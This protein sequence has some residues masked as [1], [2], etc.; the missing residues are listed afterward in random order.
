MPD[1]AQAGSGSIADPTLREAAR[2]RLPALM[3]LLRRMVEL[4]TPSGDAGRIGALAEMMAD[5]MRQRGAD[6]RTV[7]AGDAGVHLVGRF[8][9]EDTSLEPLLVLGHLDTVHAAG[10]LAEM[11]F[12]QEGERVRGPGVYDM[13]GGV[14]AVLLGADLLAEW[15]RPRGPWTLVLTADEEVGSAT[16]RALIE[17]MA[18]ESRGA[19]VPEPCIPGGRVKT[20][21]KG[22][23]VYTLTVQGRAAHAGIEPERGAS[24]VHE[25]A[26]RVVELGQM[27]DAE[28]GTTV[29]VG[30]VRG[31]TRSNVVAARAEAEVDVRFWT[32]EEAERVDRMV[33]ELRAEDPDCA[34]TVQGGINRPALERTAGSGRLFEMARQEASALGFTLDEGGTGGASDGNFSAAVGC[35]TLDGLGPDGGGAHTPDEHVL[36]EDLPRRAA[37]MAALL[38]RL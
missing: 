23:A 36:V 21:R 29:N 35:P 16:S 34:L 5:E 13:K 10:T 20:R 14:A 22:V 3:S 8:P 38:A 33:R 17:E 15:G 6:V 4:E 7:D 1:S 12:R 32:R 9:G 19:L 37:L 2:R 26:R 11:P 30:V 31:G 18:R 25:L 27:A 24:A 28:V